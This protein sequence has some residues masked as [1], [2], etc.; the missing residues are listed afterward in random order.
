MFEKQG[1][2]LY[3]IQNICCKEFNVLF[4]GTRCSAARTKGVLFSTCVKLIFSHGQIVFTGKRVNNL[5]IRISSGFLEGDDNTKPC[6]ETDGLFKGIIP[7]NIISFPAA[8]RFLHEVS[9][10]AGCI[11]NDVFG[12]R[13]GTSFK[14]CLGCSGKDR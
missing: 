6:G 10:V 5:Q 8:E 9:A 13:R 14:N 2:G 11:D 7:V 1:W 12:T 3:S 4:C